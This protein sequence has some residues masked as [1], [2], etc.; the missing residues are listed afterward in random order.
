MKKIALAAVFAGAATT[1]F[2]GSYKSYAKDEVVMEPVVVVEETQEASSSA[3]ILI[4][5]LLIA[6]VAAAYAD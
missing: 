3:G 1:A 4:P 5:L 2:A 6:I